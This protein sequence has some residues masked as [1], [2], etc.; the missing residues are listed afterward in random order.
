MG[1]FEDKV[2]TYKD[3]VKKLNLGVSD[4]LLT[5]VAK[6]LGPSIYN[7]DSE[8][9][10][11]SD[12]SE[13]Q[14]V[15]DNFLKKKLALSHSDSELESAVKEVCEKM[16]S[17]NSKKYRPIFYALLAKKFGKESVYNA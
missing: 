8:T 10:S 12:K 1:K 17:S 15:I 9:V 7:N 4:D 11:C 16:G 5:N 3:S 2:E 14:R 6:S 13:L